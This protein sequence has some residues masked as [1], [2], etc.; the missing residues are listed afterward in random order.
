MLGCPN[1]CRHCFVGWRPNPK[2]TESDLRFVAE[3]FRPYAKTLTVYDWNREPDFGGDY[4]EKWEL[5]KELS[6]PDRPPASGGWPG[7]GST[8]PGSRA[9]G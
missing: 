6:S 2:L 9:W 5:C 7:T 8:L 3:A 4:K 1:R